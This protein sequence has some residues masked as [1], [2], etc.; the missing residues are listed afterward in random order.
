M[1]AFHE[2]GIAWSCGF[3]QPYTPEAAAEWE[4]ALVGSAS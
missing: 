1:T 2:E 4:A 3:T